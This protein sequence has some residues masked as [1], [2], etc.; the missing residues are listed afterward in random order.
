VNLVL[1]AIELEF[2]ILVL[3]TLNFANFR[4]RGR[5]S[6]PT[7]K[8]EIIASSNSYIVGMN[9]YVKNIDENV[10]LVK[11]VSFSRGCA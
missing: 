4:A 1:H 6:T 2:R 9:I 7:P 3:D 10:F 8:K 5:Q 11:F